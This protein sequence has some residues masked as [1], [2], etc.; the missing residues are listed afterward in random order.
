MSV[1]YRNNFHKA[2]A[3]LPRGGSNGAK[4]TA[5]SVQGTAKDTVR[6]DTTNLQ[7]NIKLE[8]DE[9]T[10]NGWVVIVH[11]EDADYNFKQEMGPSPEEAPFGF[12][13]Y[14]RPSAEAHRLDLAANVA[15]GIREALQ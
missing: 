12:T 3:A 4:E 1:K 10:R 15:D 8:R 7:Q 11:G 2:I 13:P 9:T 14:M 5:E 6:V